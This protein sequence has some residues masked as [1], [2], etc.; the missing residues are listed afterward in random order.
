[1]NVPFAYFVQLEPIKKSSNIFE[2]LL[3][4]K[5]Y[6]YYFQIHSN[7]YFFLYG[8]K[9]SSNNLDF[10]RSA[11]KIIQELN[12]KKRQ[13]RSIRGFILYGLEII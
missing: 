5:L 12:S 4:R 3:T 6:F 9:S 11:V 8:R 13:I 2:E 10:F 7:Y 1:M